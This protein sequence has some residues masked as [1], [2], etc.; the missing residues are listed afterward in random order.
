MI[1]LQ[2]L[3]EPNAAPL[4]DLLLAAFGPEEGPEIVAL[5]AALL[6]D[7]SAEPRLCLTAVEGDSLLGMVVFSHARI[8][9]AGPE[10]KTAAAAAPTASLLAPL[11]A[12]PARH[13][14][15]IGSR[16]VRA[17][18]EHLAADGVDLVFTFGDPAYYGRFGFEPAASHGLDAPYPIQ[19]EVQDAWVVH[20]LRTGALRGAAGTL[21]CA[22]AISQPRYWQ[23]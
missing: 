22:E 6:T 21:A 8:Q 13:R 5:T 9:G 19:P 1:Q 17:G 4:S 7:A 18:F 16:L 23:F 10:P 12:A 11:A 3:R 14:Q 2:P 20:E 15:G